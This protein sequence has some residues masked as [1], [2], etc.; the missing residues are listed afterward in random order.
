MARY[1]W[2]EVTNS[3]NWSDDVFTYVEILQNIKKMAEYLN[4]EFKNEWWCKADYGDDICYIVAEHKNFPVRLFFTFD[5]DDGWAN[6]KRHYTDGASYKDEIL[7]NWHFAKYDVDY[8]FNMI[9]ENLEKY[10]DRFEEN[11]KSENK[12]LKE[13]KNHPLTKDVEKWVVDSF[14]FLDAVGYDVNFDDEDSDV[15]EVFG[16]DIDGL[17]K[18]DIEKGKENL[19]KSVPNKIKSEFPYLTTSIKKDGDYFILYAWLLK[20]D[21]YLKDKKSSYINLNESKKSLKEGYRTMGFIQDVRD[22]I[23]EVLEDS[24]SDLFDLGYCDG[25]ITYDNEGRARITSN[26][27]V[28][29]DYITL[30]TYF[31]SSGYTPNNKK[32]AKLVDDI[33]D[34]NFENARERLWD[35]NKDELIELGITD[36]DDERL[37]YNDLYDM[38]AED[39]AN[40]LSEYEMD[41]EGTDLYTDVYCQLEEVDEGVELTVSMTI[42]DEYG[43]A[44]VKDYK[45]NTVIIKEDDDL[46]KSVEDAIRK[47]TEQF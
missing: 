2:I 37:N 42:Q 38:G 32:T 3:D 11:K 47:V 40:W 17:T 13:K 26:G 45:S 4:K 18:E 20:D 23:V 46:T 8:S 30:P 36:K 41:I 5:C 7:G 39:L 21:S 43:S 6:I 27:D 19:A 29:M 14:S 31:Y 24:H 34:M 1:D 28:D 10:F 12:S 33:M 25:I 35:T 15:G 22:T 16:I 9:K 44:L